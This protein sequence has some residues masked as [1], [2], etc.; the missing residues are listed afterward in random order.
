MTAAFTFMS[1]RELSGQIQTRQLSPIELTETFLTRLENLGP[2]YNAVVTITRDL[3]LRQARQAEGEIKT[4][5]YRGPLFQQH[6]G[7]R[8]FEIKPSI[9][10]QLLSGSFEKQVQY[11]LR[12]SQ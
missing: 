7:L 6:G 9:M 10:T 12:N 8:L 3:A 4:G 1:I 2:K 5:Y 11:L